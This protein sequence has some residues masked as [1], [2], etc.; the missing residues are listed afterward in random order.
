MNPR[1]VAALAL[2]FSG[3]TAL[4]YQLLWTRLLGF[5]FGTTSESIGTVLAVFFGGMAIGNAVAARRVARL[6]SPL[7]TYALL[8]LGIGLFALASLPMLT[9][10]DLLYAW[11]GADHGSATL[12]ALRFLASAVVLL[13]PTIAM[14]ATL[15]VVAR[16][17]M[18][19]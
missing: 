16:A 8:E 17:G 10:L 7:R 13:P 11:F 3:L 12:L 14:G 9:R 5:V 18:V 6:R 19:H 1:T 2:L 15:P 4:V